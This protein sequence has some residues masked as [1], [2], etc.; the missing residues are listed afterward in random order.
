MLITQAVNDQVVQFG[1]VVDYYRRVV[2]AC[3]GEER[4]RAFARLFCSDGDIHGTIASPGPGLTT[5]SAMTALMAW[6]EQNEALEEIIAERIDVT[7]G[8]VIATRPVYPHPTATRYSGSGDPAL[9]SSYVRSP[10]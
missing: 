8:E 9:A 6:V 4:T 7:T 10:V 1:T 5:A 3:G 2:D